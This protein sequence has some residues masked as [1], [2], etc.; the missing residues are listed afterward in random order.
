MP[1]SYE[2][3]DS[4]LAWLIENRLQSEKTYQIALKLLALRRGPWTVPLLQGRF[5]LIGR[6]IVHDG[7]RTELCNRTTKSD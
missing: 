6:R 7:N 3:T 1:L 4:E 2:V 5:S